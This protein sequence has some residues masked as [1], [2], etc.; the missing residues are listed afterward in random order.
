MYVYFYKDRRDIILEHYKQA[1]CQRFNI[2]L[3]PN[4]Y[5]CTYNELNEGNLCQFLFLL[6]K[7]SAGN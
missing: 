1:S 5:N 7:K 3:F 6:K 2:K 4:L